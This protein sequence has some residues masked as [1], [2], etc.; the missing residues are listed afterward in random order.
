MVD[1]TDI[2][3]M[4]VRQWKSRPPEAHPN[5][6]ITVICS[7]GSHYSLSPASELLQLS[8]MFML[9]RESL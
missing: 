2:M 5:R 4:L 9:K 7:F 6:E 3:D 8:F 1:I